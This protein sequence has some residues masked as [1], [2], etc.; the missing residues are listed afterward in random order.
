MGG[1]EMEMELEG[2]IWNH[3]EE[4]KKK[5]SLGYRLKEKEAYNKSGSQS[6]QA[7]RPGAW[8]RVHYK[9]PMNLIYRHTEL[10]G[11]WIK[12]QLDAKNLK[13]TQISWRV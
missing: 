11:F 3:L 10:Q 5:Q 2:D 13:V 9:K 6:A 1:R 8:E 7:L 4:K 12:T